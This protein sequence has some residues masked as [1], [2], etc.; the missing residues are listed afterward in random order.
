MVPSPEEHPF[1]LSR[2]PHLADVRYEI[3]GK[4][5]HRAA[6][7]EREGHTIL[8]LNIGN[9]A[10]FGFRAPE[11]LREALIE[12]L[13]Q[14]EGYT[15]QK[16]IAPAREAVAADV[17]QKGVRGVTAD[18]VFMGNGC[19]E[20]I[21]MCMEGLL[22][23]G[24][25]VLVPSP[26]YP[27]WTAAV[28]LTGA[29]AVHYPC[30]P[31]R[32][33]V[34]DAEE[35]EA[36]VTPRTRAVVI[37]NPNNPTGAVYPREALVAIAKMAEKK[38]LVVFADEIYDRILYDGAEHVPMATLVEHTLCAS[39]GG[40]SKVHRAC[41]FRSGWVTM[42]GDKRGAADYVAGLELLSS[43]RLCA[44]VPAQ[45]AVPTALTGH[46]SIYE[47]TADEGRLGRQ[48][49]AVLDGVA[50]SKYLELVA[51]R[52]AMYAFP[53]VKLPG[54]EDRAFAMGLLEEEKVLVVPGTGF[55]VPYKDH[56]RLT[57]LPDEATMHEV[58]V[59][60]ER[61]LGRLAG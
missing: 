25:E 30:R 10:L 6:E 15:H 31:E 34:P 16:G 29:R 48:R 43:L 32:G 26:D 24:D 59:R 50:R 12:N 36:L 18:D 17:A 42:S 37:I 11:S 49:R 58:L 38:R 61:H 33:F 56:F 41:G 60:I 55:N 47:L 3:R 20:L 35:L 22:E 54:F 19:S 45:W 52:G 39:F 28:T 23:P 51:P 5:A 21:L 46:Q 1:S 44:N 4:L 8:K 13:G 14:A 40:L 9:P 53:R 57:L 2:A 27:L 7:L